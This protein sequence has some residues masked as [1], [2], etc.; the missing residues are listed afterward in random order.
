MAGLRVLSST[1]SLRVSVLIFLIFSTSELKLK[2]QLNR[3]RAAD[4]VQRIETAALPAAAQRTGQHLRG[5]AELRRAEKVDRAAE[6]G[7]VEN[8]EE[9][10]ARLKSQPLGE[11]ELA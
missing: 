2:R 7:V 6:I 4:L 10:S 5:F 11:V 8:I 1:V 3:A 9:I